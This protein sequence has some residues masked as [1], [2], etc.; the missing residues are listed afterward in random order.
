MNATESDLAKSELRPVRRFWFW[1]FLGLPAINVA[2][3]WLGHNLSGETGVP[4]IVFV[5]FLEV[6]A[7][8]RLAVSARYWALPASIFGFVILVAV[9]FA[10]F[11]ASLGLL[12]AL[13]PCD[14]PSGYCD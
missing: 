11:Y 3:F 1:A 6:I 14:N 9:T 13:T 5:A 12:Y 7:L 2:L 8:Y 10:L 4:A